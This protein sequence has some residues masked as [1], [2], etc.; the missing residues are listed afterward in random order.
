LLGEASEVGD[1]RGGREVVGGVIAVAELGV[2]REEGD[3]FDEGEG[4]SYGGCPFQVEDVGSEQHLQGGVNL[5]EESY[6]C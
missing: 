2:G 3:S 4:C 6:V 5:M 1:R